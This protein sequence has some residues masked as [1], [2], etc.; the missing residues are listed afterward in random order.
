MTFRLTVD[1]SIT[2]VSQKVEFIDF[3]NWV[4]HH[5]GTRGNAMSRVD[6]MAKAPEQSQVQW[7]IEVK[8]FR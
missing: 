6:L 8:D 2:F 5:G 3:D 4:Q 7:L 1:Q